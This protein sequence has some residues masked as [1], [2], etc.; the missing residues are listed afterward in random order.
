MINKKL[1]KAY[2][3]KIKGLKNSPEFADEVDGP[4]LMHCWEEEYN[5]SAY[6]ILFVGQE[7]NGWIGYMDDKIDT[8]IDG[9]KEFALSKN[10]NRTIFWQYVNRINSALN[11][12][13]AEGKNFLWTNVSKFSTL[14]GKGLDWDTHVSTINNF[15]CLKE[16]INA[17]KPDVVIFLSGPNYDGKINVQ[18]NNEVKFEPFKERHIREIS[19][20]EHPDL[21]QQ[22]YRIYH[23]NYLQR[24]KKSYLLD[25]LID[26]LKSKK[27]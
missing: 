10:G 6:K 18:F 24:S 8:S 27:I 25:E 9:Y 2:N 19:K 23:P 21:P 5:K 11:P 3:E 17:T 26:H 14:D 22:T 20:L 16:E 12:A 4:I 7:C 15:N 1:H 13:Q